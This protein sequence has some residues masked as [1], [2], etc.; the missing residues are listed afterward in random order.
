MDISADHMVCD[1]TTLDSMAQRFGRVNRY[2]AGDATIDL[3]YP[4]TLDAKGNP[5]D[6]ARKLTFGLLERL[7]NRAGGTR[8][9]SPAALGEMIE[10]A[11]REG[12]AGSPLA[13]DRT[14]ALRKY[15][16]SAFAPPPTIL[17]TYDILFDAWALTT[18]KGNLPG[19]P[20]VEP[21]LHGIADDGYGT[22]FAWRKEVELLT[23]EVS[24]DAIAELLDAA[25]LK[26][27]E[28]L[29]MP[30]FDKVNGAYFHLEA[31]RERVPNSPAWVIQP[32]G[33][34]TVYPTL[35]GL[36]RTTG[37]DTYSVPLAERMVVLPPKAGGLTDTGTLQGDD[38]H[39]EGRK[40]DVAGTP[41]PKVAP[42]IRLLVTPGEEE[43]IE[44]VAPVEG[45]P[46]GV[47]ITRSWR[48]FRV[49]GQRP[50]RV[51]LA[52]DIPDP[53]DD[54]APPQQ[55]VIVRPVKATDGKEVSPEWPALDRHLEGVA[56]FAKEIV[57]RLEL[58]PKLAE[59]VVLAAKWHDH[60][61]ARTVWQRGGKS[62]GLRPGGE[63]APWPARRRT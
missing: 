18:I 55:Y 7:R 54:D 8:D 45:W 37:K 62:N 42:L 17:P 38:P 49:P 56:G 30:T 21:Y 63:D 15:I 3:V 35:A 27:H 36:L 61:K 59:A 39:T 16:L 32:N 4:K 60:G 34:V 19:R 47:E 33:D 22:E 11:I 12:S 52:L 29:R 40:Y 28:T 58:D 46:E 20:H 6:A 13:S 43:T 23:G 10:N 25:P 1:L 41:P 51:S 2:G 48:T 31:I 14:E 57:S 9:A 26:P 5:F 53:D 50:L 24:G 44:P